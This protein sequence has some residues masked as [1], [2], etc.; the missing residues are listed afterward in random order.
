MRYTGYKQIHFLNKNYNHI[1]T[2]KNAFKY[3]CQKYCDANMSKTSVCLHI[4]KKLF[5]Y[6]DAT[7]SFIK[8]GCLTLNPR[9]IF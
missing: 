1:S 9:P 3:T 7:R 2:E 5:S 8:L 6:L 4:Q